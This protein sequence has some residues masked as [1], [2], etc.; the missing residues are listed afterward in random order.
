MEDQEGG[1]SEGW[2]TRRVE[3]Q[4]GA[5]IH[6]LRVDRFQYTIRVLSVHL[7]RPDLIRNTLR[8]M[9][10]GTQHWTPAQFECD[11]RRPSSCGILV[12]S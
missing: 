8:T 4:K 12:N 5:S 11:A 9:G 6:T 10:T 1:G 7:F 3:D 2:R